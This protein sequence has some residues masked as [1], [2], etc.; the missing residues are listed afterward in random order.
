MA[1]VLNFFSAAA[2]C[3]L[4]VTVSAALSLSVAASF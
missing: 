4:V 2:V 1:S 3:D